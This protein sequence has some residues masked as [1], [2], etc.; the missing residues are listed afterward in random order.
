MGATVIGLLCHAGPMLNCL[1]KKVLDRTLPP[2]KKKLGWR[3][4]SGF[5]KNGL[6]LFLCVWASFS[7]RLN[8]HQSALDGYYSYSEWGWA[9]EEHLSGAE[10][11]ASLCARPIKIWARVYKELSMFILVSM[12]Q[13]SIMLMSIQHIRAN[14]VKTFRFGSRQNKAPNS[15][16]SMRWLMAI[17]K[18]TNHR[19]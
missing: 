4:L 15:K 19:E 13:P 3:Q 8:N 1:A 17:N 5:S 7:R 18:I 6:Y 2:L 9:T 11:L 16:V 10:G 12:N 14:T